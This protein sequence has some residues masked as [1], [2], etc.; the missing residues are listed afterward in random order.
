MD[1]LPERIAPGTQR[2]PFIAGQPPANAGAISGCPF[3]PRCP[4]AMPGICEKPLPTTRLTHEGEQALKMVGEFGGEHIVHCHLYPDNATV[5]AGVVEAIDFVNEPKEPLVRVTE[6]EIHFPLGGGK[7]VRAVDGVSLTIDKRRDAGAGRRIRLRQIDT[8]TRPAPPSTGDQ[9]RCHVRGRGCAG[10]SRRRRQRGLATTAPPDADRVSGPVRV[11]LAAH[12][13][14]RDRRRTAGDS[15]D[16]R[17]LARRASHTGRWAASVRRTSR[18]RRR[19]LPA[20]VFRR[21]SAS[22]SASPGRSRWNRNS[23]CWTNPFRRWTFRC[24]R[25]LSIFSPTC[26]ANAV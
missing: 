3:R 25:R 7:V 4:K 1:S 26:S 2:L 18:R 5:P 19:A 17:K 13:D 9:R 12:D 8:G 23:S 6:L 15:S 14:R 24:A 10:Y 21:D 16:R 20:R 22:V 11:A